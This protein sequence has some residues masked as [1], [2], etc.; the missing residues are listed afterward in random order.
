MT[1]DHLTPV[2]VLEI[3][4]P[5]W[6]DRKVLLAKFKVGTHNKIVFTNA[7]SLDGEYYISGRKASACPQ[8][9]NGKLV[10][11]AVPLDELEPFERE[12]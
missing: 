10:C 9:S 12:V 8:V 1:L 3:K 2:Q 4:A 11:Y 6:H 5:R 7:P